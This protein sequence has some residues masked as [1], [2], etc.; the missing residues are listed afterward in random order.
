MKHVL[1][2]ILTVYLIVCVPRN[3]FGADS[4]FDLY[5]G[6]NVVLRCMDTRKH[7]ETGSG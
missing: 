7:A 1:E 2:K 5:G 6:L 4:E 3:H